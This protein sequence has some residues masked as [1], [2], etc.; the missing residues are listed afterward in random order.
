MNYTQ[1]DVKRKAKY[2]VSP[3]PNAVITKN[4]RLVPKKFGNKLY[5]YDDGVK[6]YYRSHTKNKPLVDLSI[7]LLNKGLMDDA[8]KQ[9]R[10]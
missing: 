6:A 2:A 9:Q 8:I 1:R 5:E 7:E 10:A 4:G 3:F